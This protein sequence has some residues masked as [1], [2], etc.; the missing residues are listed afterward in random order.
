M[1]V[2]PPG[3]SPSTSTTDSD[4]L[5]AQLVFTVE[6]AVTL[7]VQQLVPALIVLPANKT[8]CNP[9]RYSFTGWRSHL[10]PG[11]SPYRRRLS[12]LRCGEAKPLCS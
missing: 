8:N 11:S 9:H 12:S 7:Q 5:S 4:A 1:S 3:H 10:Q 6:R 2:P